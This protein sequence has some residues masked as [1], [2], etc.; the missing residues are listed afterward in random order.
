MSARTP[1]LT[2]AIPTY[3]RAAD[4]AAA[5][6]HLAGQ[7]GISGGEVELLVSDNC[8]TDATGEV[9]K[10]FIERGLRIGYS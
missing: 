1:L 9:V 7:P 5:L 4:L 2:I 10:K 6:E 3:N 8:S